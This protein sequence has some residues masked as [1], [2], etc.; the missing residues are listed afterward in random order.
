MWL[1]P[2][3]E[4][5]SPATPGGGA[6]GAPRYG[7][8]G[9]AGGPAE[10]P[11]AAPLWR[12]PRAPAAAR[13]ARVDHAVDGRRLGRERVLAGQLLRPQHRAGRRVERLHDPVAVDREDLAGV[14]G[15]ARPVVAAAQRALPRG[16]AGGGVERDDPRP[17]RARVAHDHEDLAARDERIG[18]RL[19]QG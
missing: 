8:R 3:P 17:V 11:G 12:G 18:G 16:R 6:R 2:P 9:P 13:A 7:P 5:G 15:G 14:V 1:P 4:T 19:A 10:A